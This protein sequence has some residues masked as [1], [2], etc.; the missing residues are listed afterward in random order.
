MA[1]DD[2]AEIMLKREELVQKEP[3]HIGF[4]NEASHE[5]AS[6]IINAMETNRPFKFFKWLIGK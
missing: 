2:E 6:N 1:P 3:D 4:K 5:Y